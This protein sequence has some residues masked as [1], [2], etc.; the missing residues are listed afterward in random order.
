MEEQFLKNLSIEDIEKIKAIKEMLL[1]EKSDLKEDGV[2]IDR[3]VKEYTEYVKSNLSY[4]Y[5]VSVELAFK[6]LTKFF[7]GAAML[8]SI[9][10]REVE[11]FMDHIRKSAP[12]GYRVYYRTLKAAFNKAID[13]GYIGENYFR[14]YKLP[15]KQRNKPEYITEDELNRIL[16]RL[17]SK[18][19]K[20]GCNKSK[21]RSL[22][23]IADIVL[24]AFYSGMRLGELLSLRWENVRL[25]K[26]TIT[27]GDYKFTT[28]GR[29]QRT[30]PMC[31]KLAKCLERRAL[32]KNVNDEFV[33]GI[34]SKCSLT[35]DYVS[36][37]FKEICR[38][39]KIDERIK[40]HSLRHSFASYLAQRGVSP[41]Q[42]KELLGHSSITISEIYS[43]LNEESLK[44]AVNKFN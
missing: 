9:Q 23:L 21:R 20:I 5:V 17:D 15:K 40:F 19:N 25:E 31:D 27:V 42:L 33:F 24:T 36:K 29:K 2:T 41:Y 6:H 43:H 3:F 35:K 39:E 13:W 14:K 30:I 11:K 32:C 28:K 22:L 26:M 18:A 34:S 37:T 4:S 12:D 8:K 44:A 16:S 10:L 1:N 38:I 7:S